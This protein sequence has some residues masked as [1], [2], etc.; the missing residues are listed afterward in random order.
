[1]GLYNEVIV[2][3]PD[4]GETYVHQSKAGSCQLKYNSLDTAEEEDAE[5][6]LEDVLN[7]S[8]Y[9]SE[10]HHKFTA[11]KKVRKVSDYFIG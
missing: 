2:E 8:V 5:D 11:Q 3:C 4:C 1:M 7:E 6:F 10:C 9:C